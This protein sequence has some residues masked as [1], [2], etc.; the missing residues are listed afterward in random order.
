MY[1]QIAEIA[2]V[3]IPSIALGYTVY[4]LNQAYGI[5]SSI[6]PAPQAT[7]MSMVVEGVI[8]GNLPYSLVGIGAL[9]AVAMIIL[10]IP[11]LPFALGV[12]L[13]LS[14]STA[15]MLGGIVKAYVDRRK[16][17]ESSQERGI[18]LASGLIGGDACIGIL[19]AFGALSKVIPADK[20]GILPNWV[21]LAAFVLLALGLGFM[22][23]RKRKDP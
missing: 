19:L 5:G 2:G 17:D 4:I 14:L 18:L 12:Y 10:R 11:V 8:S 7:L 1:Q 15:T 20:P 22:T 9:L 13:P 6:M 23:L 3:I 16:T 21:S